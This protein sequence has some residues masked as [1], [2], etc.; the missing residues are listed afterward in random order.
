MYAVDFDQT[1]QERIDKT[2][3]TQKGVCFDYATIFTKIANA[4]G[5]KTVIISGYTKQ[6]D[7]VSNL[8]HAWCAARVDNKWYVFDP[9]WGS[10][11][12]NN[13]NKKYTRNASFS[14]FKID[15]ENI[16]DSH[17]PFDY[18]WQ[19]S[20]YPI[21]NQEFI[22]G[23]FSI[24]KNKEKFDYLYEIA[25]LDTLQKAKIHSESA[26]RIEKN[27]MKNQLISQAYV[28]A[29]RSWSYERDKEKMAVFNE[30]NSKINAIVFRFNEAIKGL[31]SFGH[32]RNK[33][34]QP[35]A[36]D[37]EI[38]KKIQDP[39]DELVYCKEAISALENS[40]LQNKTNFN[41]LKN[42][43]FQTLAKAEEHLQ[44]VNL[45]LAKPKLVRKTMFYSVV[46]R[47]KPN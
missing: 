13:T 32:Y 36:S 14:F 23:V 35:I 41:N 46:S 8:S 43:I 12:V 31:N 47:S 9:T 10:G 24:D 21:T 26:N 4:T 3:K 15:P 44:F 17:M 42:N 37:E 40:N 45:Y 34:F 25:K 16:I 29:K 22:D 39:R 27:G 19:F 33:Q 2:L 28:N 6:N 5:V 7:R 30:T 1:P 18:L 11:Y 20:D 38:K